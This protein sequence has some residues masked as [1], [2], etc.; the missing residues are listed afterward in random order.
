MAEESGLFPRYIVNDSLEK[1]LEEG[2][3]YIVDEIYEMKV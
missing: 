2:E 3:R 1:F